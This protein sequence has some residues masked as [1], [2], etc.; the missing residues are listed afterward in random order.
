MAPSKTLMVL[1]VTILLMM[2][3]IQVLSAESSGIPI[4][5]RKLAQATATYSGPRG[6]GGCYPPNC[7]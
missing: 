7:D 4:S 2:S 3:S 6:G 5:R 1:F